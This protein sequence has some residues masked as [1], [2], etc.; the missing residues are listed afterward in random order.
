MNIV[1]YIIVGLL[2]AMT[3]VAFA[4]VIYTCILAIKEF[5]ENQ[6]CRWHKVDTGIERIGKENV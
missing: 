2:L 4:I 6:K 5:K 3:F 1:L